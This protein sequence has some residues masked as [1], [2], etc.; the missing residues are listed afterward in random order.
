M[1]KLCSLGNLATVSEDKAKAA[2]NA[3]NVRHHNWSLE[4]QRLLRF[5]Q[6]KVLSM[7]PSPSNKGM[8]LTMTRRLNETFTSFSWS[9]GTINWE[10]GTMS[11]MR[12]NYIPPV[13][14]SVSIPIG[15]FRSSIPEN[16]DQWLE[17]TIE[18]IIRKFA[19]AHHKQFHAGAT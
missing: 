18:A 4:L 8:F 7:P 17:G 6:P 15:E 11:W 5:Q 12:L 3:L 2:S 13:D 1:P 14:V 16:L 19:V 10:G 9:N